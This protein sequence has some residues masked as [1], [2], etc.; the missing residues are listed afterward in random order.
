M[1]TFQ[2]WR[3]PIVSE[4]RWA[5]L[6]P[7]TGFAGDRAIEYLRHVQTVPTPNVRGEATVLAERAQ[8][9]WR[10]Q[11]NLMAQGLLKVGDR[12]TP[13]KSKLNTATYHREEVV[14]PK[15]L[16]SWFLERRTKPVLWAMQRSWAP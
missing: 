6:I 15:R 2:D 13:K 14:E 16:R 9:A 4:V 1:E 10:S 8:A 5:A 11:T 12:E 7:M 3:G